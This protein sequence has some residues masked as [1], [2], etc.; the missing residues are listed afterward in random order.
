M[1]GTVAGRLGTKSKRND[2]RMC[3]ACSVGHGAV[4]FLDDTYGAQHLKRI[5]V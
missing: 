1:G 5:C 2:D 3:N 4:H